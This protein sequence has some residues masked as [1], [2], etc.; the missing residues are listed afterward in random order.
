MNTKPY[1]TYVLRCADGTLYCGYSDNVKK[2]LITH[3][4][5]KGA[6]YTKSRL[7][8]VLVTSVKFDNKSDA[9]KCEWWFKNK[10]NRKK[11]LDLIMN[12]TI[13][14]NYEIYKQRKQKNNLL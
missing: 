4:T 5:G 6:K 11:K 1:Y 10:L 2:R 3:N 8:V 7:P 9:T 14:L 12:Q 13:K